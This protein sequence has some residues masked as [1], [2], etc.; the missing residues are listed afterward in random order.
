M[1]SKSQSILGGG[2]GWSCPVTCQAGTEGRY[3]STH[4]RT[5]HWKWVD[6]QCYSPTV[7][8]V[9]RADWYYCAGG[10]VGLGPVL[11]GKTSFARH[12]RF[13]ARSESYQLRYHDS[14]GKKRTLNRDLVL[15]S[16]PQRSV[17]HRGC[18]VQRRGCEEF[19]F[20]C[21]DRPCIDFTIHLH[22]EVM[23]AGIFASRPPLVEW[24]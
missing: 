1:P 6:G 17:G 16:W 5:P 13:E 9:Y 21:N 7:L 11:T 18:L 3:S 8:P 24:S 10:W 14:T 20:G 15:F 12:R 2:G 23:N 22:L 4:S 19:F